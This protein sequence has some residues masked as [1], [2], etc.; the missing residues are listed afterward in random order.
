VEIPCKAC[1]R[2]HLI[3]ILF[4]VTLSIDNVYESGI[5]PKEREVTI[6][7]HAH[8]DDLPLVFCM[9]LFYAVLA[10]LFCV[11]SVLSLLSDQIEFGLFMMSCFLLI[12]NEH[13]ILRE[14]IE[15]FFTPV[16]PDPPRYPPESFISAPHS[17]ALFDIHRCFIY[18]NMGDVVYKCGC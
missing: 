7:L 18:S 2:C 12:W 9:R 8:E 11:L 16:D 6:M 4:V 17:G 1:T 15:L 5:L 10:A 14:W 3:N 13:E